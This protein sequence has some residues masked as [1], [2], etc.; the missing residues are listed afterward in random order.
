MR[1]VFCW[2]SVCVCLS[3]CARLAGA[4]ELSKLS[5]ADRKQ[6]NEWMDQRAMAMIDAH[7]LES[8]LNATWSNAAYTSPEIETLRARYSELQQELLRTQREI[9]KKV[10]EVP[11]LKAKVLQ[12]EEMKR[13]Q[14]E[15]SKK[16]AEKVGE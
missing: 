12:L 8:E 14:Q 9:Q 1:R 7:K 2:V 4:E 15:L 11:A 5:E 10:R 3:V 6:V 13:R 16:I